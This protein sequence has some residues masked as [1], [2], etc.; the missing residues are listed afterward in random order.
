MDIVKNGLKE[1]YIAM[2]SAFIRNILLWEILLAKQATNVFIFLRI[3][4]LLVVIPFVG[5][6]DKN[7]PLLGCIS[8]SGCIYTERYTLNR[9]QFIG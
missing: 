5:G 6:C 2:S 7:R 1:Y 9:V 8:Y 3:D 4:F